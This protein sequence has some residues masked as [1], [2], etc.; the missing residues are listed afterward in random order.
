MQWRI[1]C[2]NVVSDSRG[3]REV[4]EKL[5]SV[6]IVPQLEPEIRVGHMRQ[7]FFSAWVSNMRPA[8]L[9]YAVRGHIYKLLSP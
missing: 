5:T 4:D 7:S 9:Y 6:E 8:R 1:L 3:L 2:R